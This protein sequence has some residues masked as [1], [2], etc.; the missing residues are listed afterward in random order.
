LALNALGLVVDISW[1]K[2]KDPNVPSYFK[3]RLESLSDFP[4]WLLSSIL[5]L[6]FN[7]LFLLKNHAIIAGI[8]NGE[9]ELK[10]T[11]VKM[12]GSNF[13][14]IVILIILY[15]VLALSHSHPPPKID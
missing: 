2:E 3:L 7:G 15:L 1:S 14:Y 4:Y 9:A 6:A 12:L 8:R 13:V 5:L 10:L 11:N